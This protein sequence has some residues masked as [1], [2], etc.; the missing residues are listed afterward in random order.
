MESMP[1]VNNNCK[2]VLTKITEMIEEQTEPDMMSNSLNLKKMGL[3]R[4]STA[5]LT[6][7]LHHPTE[8]VR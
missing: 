2:E 3:F 5:K 4:P 1:T 6:D 7:Y 8:E